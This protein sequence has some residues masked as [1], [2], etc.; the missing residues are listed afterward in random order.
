MKILKTVF[1][2]SIITV[3]VLIFVAIFLYFLTYVC[4]RS[5]EEAVKGELNNLQ[6]KELQDTTKVKYEIV[7]VR[8]VPSGDPKR[9]GK[10]DIMVIY[11][12]EG[13]PSDMI[14]IP[15]E[16]AS[17]ERIKKAIVE[18][19]NRLNIDIGKE[20]KI[21]SIRDV[22]SL[23][24]GRIGKKDVMI[25]YQKEGEYS[26]YITILKEKESPEMIKRAILENEERKKELRK[27]VEP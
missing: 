14:T 24:P 23:K 15:K 8:E 21:L 17:P 18:R 6:T 5:C 4:A 3:T 22:P 16:E 20:Y 9:I 19:E 27:L 7:N 1:K 2:T 25:T 13:K 11:Q 12:V 10:I 26:D